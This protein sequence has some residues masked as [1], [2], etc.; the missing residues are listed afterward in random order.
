MKDDYHSHKYDLLGKCEHCGIERR[1]TK[2]FFVSGKIKES[3]YEYLVD[4]EWIRERPNC[5]LK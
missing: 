1:R 3:F 2:T 5:K 4:G